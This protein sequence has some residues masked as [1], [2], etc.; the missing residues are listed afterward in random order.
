MNSEIYRISKVATAAIMFSVILI[1]A[2]CEKV[3]ITAPSVDPN[4]TWTLSSDIQPIFTSKCA[5]CHNGTKPADLRAGKSYTSLTNKGFV[6]S[7]AA[8]SVLYTTMTGSDHLSRSTDAE[9][10]KVLY[11]I[12]QGALNN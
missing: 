1:L 5:S 11:W 4:A 7:P 6:T 12:Q 8:S 10:L 3:Q 9:K 2:S